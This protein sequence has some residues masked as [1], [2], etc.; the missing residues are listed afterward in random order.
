MAPPVSPLDD[1]LRA[2]F[3]PVQ[4]SYA[5]ARPFELARTEDIVAEQIA[6]ANG[7]RGRVPL[8]RDPIFTPLFTALFSTTFL[9]GAASWTLFGG[10]VTLASV[11]SAI[12]VTALTIGIQY[13]LAP[14]PPKPEAG[15]APLTQAVP[16]RMWGVGECRLAGAMMLWEAVDNKLYS[17]QALVAHP[18]DSITSYYLN[19]DRVTLD[20]NGGVNPVP[21]ADGRYRSGGNQA[22]S[23]VIIGTRLGAVPE[24]AYPNLVSKLGSQ[25]VWTNNHRG[26]GQASLSMVC[27]SPSAQDFSSR[28]PYGKPLASVVAKWAKMWDLRDPAQSPTDPATWR[29]S[30]NPV[31]ILAWHLCFSPFGEKRDYRRAILPVLDMWQEEAGVC[32]ELVALASGGTEKRYICSG[33][34][35]TEH[36]PKSATNAILATMDAWMCTRGDGATLIVAGKY[37]E[38]YC[39]VLTDADVIGY[40]NQRDV[41]FDEEVNRFTPKFNYPAIDYASSDTDF[42]EDIPAQIKAGRPLPDE[43]NYD[44]CT[45]WR[46]ARRLGKRDWIR[47][48]QKGRGSIFANLTGLNAAYAPWVR[49]RTP[50]MIP[51][52]DGKVISNRKATLNLQK[53]GLQIDFIRMP[54]NPGDIDIWIPATDEGSAPP[55]PIKP[56]SDGLPMPV[57]DSIAVISNA[58]AVYLRVSLIDPNRQDVTPLIRYRVSGGAWIDQTFSDVAPT[59][60]LI[61]LNTNPVP[62]DKTLEV[63]AA[64]IGS[65]NTRGPTSASQFVTSTVDSTPPVALLTYSASGAAGQ[66]VV[67]FGTANDSHLATVAV[68]RVPAGG[69]LD[70]VAHLATRPAV[71]PG[72]SYAIPVSS[73]A[74]SFDIYAEPQNR[75]GVAG[76][77]AG[78]STVTVT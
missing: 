23:L 54:D 20:G 49:L 33:W 43:G 31:V 75:S 29:W 59:A 19:D 32:D 73:S 3:T 8:H 55:V 24:T 4:R 60:G 65:N 67:N 6:Q 30:N 16:Y 52:L 2:A 25:G 27:E 13:A 53:G 9:G 12:A 50:V 35:T 15:R 22:F 5:F 28:F 45:Q 44:W 10:A 37:R 61:V 21:G 71:S 58:G 38:K 70:K 40:A 46:Q 14:K 51:A 76:P 18:I 64:Y 41:L 56:T 36:P 17:V 47:I 72:I 7:L 78:P 62:G 26:D 11:A 1:A 57:I 74:G 39:A 68:Y 66:F 42:F 77:L 69:T 63:Q 48:R 34:D